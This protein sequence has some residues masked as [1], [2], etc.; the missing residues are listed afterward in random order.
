MLIRGIEHC[1]TKSIS[2]MWSK[3]WEQSARVRSL[4]NYIVLQLNFLNHLQNKPFKVPRSPA[5]VTSPKVIK[6]IHNLYFLAIACEN[7]LLI[8]KK[9]FKQKILFIRFE[10]VSFYNPL[11]RALLSEKNK[12]YIMVGWCPFS[13]EKV[14]FF[15][16]LTLFSFFI[17]LLFDIRKL[18]SADSVCPTYAA[19]KLARLSSLLFPPSFQL[20]YTLYLVCVNC[21]NIFD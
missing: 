6:C 9:Y 2:C 10:Y 5:T 13:D 18:T 11:Y 21:G 15:F 12:S 8:L 14:V 7:C 1:K 19:R 3:L 17:I 16:S 4:R 20:A